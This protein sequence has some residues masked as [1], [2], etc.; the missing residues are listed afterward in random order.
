MKKIS[1]FGHKN[2]DTDSVCGAI[3]LSYLKNKLGYNSNP[4]I[5]GDINKETEFVLNYFK[6]PIP[7]Y[8]NNV[9]VKIKDVF[10]HKDYY[11]KENESIYNSYFF[12]NER[13][14]TGVPLVNNDKKFVGYV[15]LK[16]IARSMITESMDY[17]D[18][19]FDNIVSTLKSINYVKIDDEIK[20]RI[21]AATFDDNTFINNVKLDNNTILIVGDRHKILDYAILSKVKLII[22]IGNIELMHEHLIME[23][24]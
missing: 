2:P 3:S 9:K 21:V 24:E 15:S 1:I 12:M 5:L 20:G 19:T 13:N 22:L 4:R 14:I 7:K 18:T 11:V 8:L 16:E 23:K 10:Y 6:V 17:L